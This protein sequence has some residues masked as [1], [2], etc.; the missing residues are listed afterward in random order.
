MNT[1]AI[2]TAAGGDDSAFVCTL[3]NIQALSAEVQGKW[4]ACKV[5]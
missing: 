3:A 1:L 2:G 5:T 4:D